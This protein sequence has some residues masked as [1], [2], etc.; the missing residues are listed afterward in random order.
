MKILGLIL[1]GGGSS[2]MGHDKSTL[3]IGGHSMLA[4]ATHSLRECAL[5]AVAA[6]ENELPEDASMFHQIRDSENYVGPR[7]GLFPGL[8]FAVENEFEFVQL[9]PCDTPLVSPDLFH[10]LKEGLKDADCCV[11]KTE[12]GIHPLHA[13]VRTEK[14]LAALEKD[15]ETSNIHSL[16]TS[17]THNEISTDNDMML[18]INSPEDMELL[19]DLDLIDL[20]QRRQ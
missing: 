15:G 11:P 13:L 6:G 1:A 5:I 19:R 14:F 4:L 7:A 18:N 17:L 8:M 12:S 16:V 3:E 10:E 2:R 20:Q 9:S